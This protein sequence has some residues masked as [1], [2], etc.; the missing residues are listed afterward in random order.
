MFGVFVR[1]ISLNYFVVRRTHEYG[2][3]DEGLIES[4]KL[5]TIFV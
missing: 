5:L 4:Q 3:L 2:M 1:E